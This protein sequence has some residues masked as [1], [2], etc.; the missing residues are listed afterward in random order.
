MKKT[1]LLII[2]GILPL[3]SMAQSGFSY[4]KG[5]RGSVEASFMGVLNNNESG[6]YS[7]IEMSHGYS[8]GNGAYFGA[9]VG[10]LT[11]A[12]ATYERFP[13]FLDAKYSFKNAVISPFVQAR[14]GICVSGSAARGNIISVGGGLDFGRMSCKIAYSLESNWDR[15]TQN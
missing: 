7:G 14:G 2:L 15:V 11:N 13:I 5:Y 10:F 8:F 4:R 3:V 9:G 1:L 6:F 12:G